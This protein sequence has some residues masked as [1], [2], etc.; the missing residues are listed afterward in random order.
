MRLGKVHP[1][2]CARGAC[3]GWRESAEKAKRGAILDAA[4][5]VFGEQGLE[6]PTMDDIA[7]AAGYSRRS[8]YRFFESKDEIVAAAALRSC[9]T[10]LDSLG[11]V[12]SLSLFD[13]V[14]TYYRFSQEEPEGFGV[15][16]EMRRWLSDGRSLPFTRELA[17][18]DAAFL[19]LLEARVGDLGGEA[20]AAALGYVEF[21]FRYGRSWSQSGLAGDEAEVR[22]VLEG[23][24]TKENV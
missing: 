11:P 24:L 10:L 14:W 2:T 8:L 21:R 9:R 6:G 12:G 3:V 4:L 20:V 22:A 7:A 23:L 13:L 16:L 19:Q 5:R 18:E 1:V 15:M 17:S